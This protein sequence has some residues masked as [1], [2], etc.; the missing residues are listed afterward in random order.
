MTRN[1]NEL[2]QK[3][4]HQL[5]DFVPPQAVQQVVDWLLEHN[6]HLKISRPRKTILGDY[7]PPQRGKGHRISVNG[8]LNPFAFLVTFTHEVAHLTTYKQF[9]QKVKPHGREWKHEYSQLMAGHL[10]K[11]VFPNDLERAVAIHLQNPAAS[12]CVDTVLLKALRQYDS[13]EKKESG[14]VP[15]ETLPFNQLFVFPNDER[16]F[17]KGELMRTRFRCK[18]L[19]SGKK[20]AVNK[21]AEVFPVYPK[22]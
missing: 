20:F 1:S 12:S 15:V 16:I 19:R 4:T 17:V 21:L 6:I 7:R 2:R 8:D 22:E 10:I 5:S 18:E 9:Q 3:L 14:L 13:E 11:E